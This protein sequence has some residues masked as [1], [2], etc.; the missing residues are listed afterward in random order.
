MFATY[1][2]LRLRRLRQNPAMR[3]LVRETELTLH[4]LILPLFIKGEQGEKQK[5][6]SMPGHFQIPL[7]ALQEEIKE[8]LALGISAVILFG[9]PAKKDLLGS[10]SYSDEGIIQRAL[11]LIREVAPDLLVITDL[12]FCEYTSHGHCG[13]IKNNQI[14]NDSTLEILAKQVLVLHPNTVVQFD[15]HKHFLHR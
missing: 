12:C 1:P 10:D 13:I 2:T 7:S 4:R 8:L 11:R 5:I 6:S 14:D 3:T 9:V 15:Q